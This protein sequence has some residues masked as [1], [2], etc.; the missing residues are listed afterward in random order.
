MIVSSRFGYIVV[1]VREFNEPLPIAVGTAPFLFAFIRGP[2]S[3]MP[4][5]LVFEAAVAAIV[6]IGEIVARNFRP[7]LA[8]IDL[9]G[10]AR[11]ASDEP[12][13]NS[14]LRPFGFGITRCS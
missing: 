10:S 4:P 8:G 5:S 2:N 11:S 6:E 7:S 13:G 9:P 3:Q 12:A 14:I 1:G